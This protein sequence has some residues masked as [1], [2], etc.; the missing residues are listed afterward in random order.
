MN[1]DVPKITSELSAQYNLEL[2]ETYNLNEGSKMK[3]RLIRQFYL[4]SKK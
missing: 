1:E 2:K 3:E 4:I